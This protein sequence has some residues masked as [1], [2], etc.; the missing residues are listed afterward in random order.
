MGGQVR[1]EKRMR[2]IDCGESLIRLGDHRRIPGKPIGMPHLDEQA[3]GRTKT[4]RVGGCPF[5]DIEKP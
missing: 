5:R 1:L 2:R 4:V 3:V